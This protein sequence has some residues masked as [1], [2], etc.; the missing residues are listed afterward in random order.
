V[1]N[2]VIVIGHLAKES[3]VRQLPSGLSL[4]SFD[5][6]VPRSADQASETVPVALFDTPEST[7]GFR[8]GQELVVVGRVRRRFFRVS[9]ATQSR[10]EVVADQV[11]AVAQKDDVRSTLTGV[12]DRLALVAKEIGERSS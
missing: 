6:L 7:P 8:S 2:L 1:L 5:L 10:T 12:S 11:L 4:A 9:G 3:Q